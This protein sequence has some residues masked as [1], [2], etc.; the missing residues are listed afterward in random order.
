MSCRKVRWHRDCQL[1]CS[2][3]SKSHAMDGRGSGIRR[4][5]L[6]T[7]SCFKFA[8]GGA[9][10]GHRPFAHGEIGNG[11]RRAARSNGRLA[12]RRD[13]HPGCRVV[14]VD[15]RLRPVLYTLHKGAEHQVIHAVVMAPDAK[16]TVCFRLHRAVYTVSLLTS[17]FPSDNVQFSR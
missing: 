5:A 16:V 11:H 12:Q 1:R 14:D 2:G 4:L 8:S 10:T 17:A 15:G 9:A 7:F 6:R 13:A 3:S